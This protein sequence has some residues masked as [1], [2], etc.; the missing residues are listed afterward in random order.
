[1]FV[2]FLPKISS[3]DDLLFGLLLINKLWVVWLLLTFDTVGI[4]LVGRIG[5]V[6]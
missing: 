1:M 4:V 6:F 5:M 2:L 3:Y